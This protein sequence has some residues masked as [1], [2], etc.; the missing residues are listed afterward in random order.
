MHSIPSWNGLTSSLSIFSWGITG[1]YECNNNTRVS[2]AS[3][4]WKLLWTNDVFCITCILVS[5]IKNNFI[6]VQIPQVWISVLTE[7]SLWLLWAVQNGKWHPWCTINKLLLSQL[8]VVWHVNKERGSILFC[9]DL[10]AL[11]VCLLNKGIFDSRLNIN[12]SYFLI[13]RKHTVNFQNQR[14]WLHGCLPFV[15]LFF[16]KKNTS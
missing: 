16:C 8:S 13:G 11:F 15:E 10:F 2:H 5:C 12:N 1:P 3:L 4:L 9:I 6:V 7:R 14:P